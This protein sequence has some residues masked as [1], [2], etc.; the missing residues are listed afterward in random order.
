MPPHEIED[1]ELKKQYG[2]QMI[3]SYGCAP[4]TPNVP[5]FKVFV[6][7][8]TRT[9]EDGIK[10]EVPY[11]Q[12]VSR[13]KELGLDI[14]P[15]L[16]ESFIYDGDKEK[17]YELCNSL[18]EGPSTLDPSHIKEGVVIR[19]EHPNQETNYKC[20]SFHFCMLEGIQKNNPEF[21]DEEESN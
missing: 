1:K 10:S 5:K 2:D 6:Y 7:R 18:A 19:V 17:L 11:H 13:C 14:V 4:N 3:Y 8:M 12:L 20:K 21:V 9:N 16:K 15:E